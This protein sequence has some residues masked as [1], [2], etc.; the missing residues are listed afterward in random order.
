[1]L[2]YSSFEHRK[3]TWN[4]F[5]SGESIYRCGAGPERDA[6]SAALVFKVY[7]RVVSLAG[8]ACDLAMRGELF[9]TSF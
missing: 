8:L 9:R 1:L 6:V 4:I 5:V 7:V 3:N 2:L